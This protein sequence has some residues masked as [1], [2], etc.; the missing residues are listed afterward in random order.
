MTETGA[1]RAYDRGV[2][3]TSGRVL[4]TYGYYDAHQEPDGSLVHSGPMRGEG[5]NYVAP[6]G[7][8]YTRNWTYRSDGSPTGIVGHGVTGPVVNGRHHSLL[9]IVNHGNQTYGQQHTEVRV[10]DAAPKPSILG[11]ESSAAEV[12]EAVRSGVAI[13]QGRTMIHDLPAI[14][15]SIPQPY[16][17]IRLTL[18]IDERTHQPLR[19]V[20]V[21]EGE[22]SGGP[23]I[24]DWMPATP[25]NIA[26]AVHDDFIPTGYTKVDMAVALTRPD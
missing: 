17:N 5:Y 19:T 22:Q 6:D 20:T 9:T 10:S 26:R 7:T 3:G 24:A 12:R 21:I 23:Y 8:R 4:H 16:P 11:V 18:F 13:R 1:R 25:D 14:T 15:L 2:T